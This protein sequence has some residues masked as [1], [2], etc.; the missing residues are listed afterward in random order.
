[1]ANLKFKTE[2]GWEY[3]EDP[4]AKAYAEDLV[5]N[6]TAPK[7]FEYI[8]RVEVKA[9]EGLP[10]TLSISKDQSGNDFTLTDF[11]FE[12]V[13]S[14][15]SGMLNMAIINNRSTFTMLGNLNVTGIVSKSKWAMLY[16]TY[17]DGS[18]PCISFPTKTIDY[19]LNNNFPNKYICDW[20]TVFVPSTHPDTASRYN[21]I[22]GVSLSCATST[23][24]FADGTYLSLYG[25][26]KKDT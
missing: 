1:M 12:L 24:T 20:G 7:K 21:V 25:V 2:N 3:V 23:A 11:Y 8:G 18:A 17:R 16:E 5:M 13:G 14:I 4:L 9:A 26:R 6:A 19:N 15:T 22:S 10:N